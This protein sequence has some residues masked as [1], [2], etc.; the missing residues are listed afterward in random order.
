ML[1]SF[2]TILEPSD[3]VAYKQVLEIIETRYSAGLYRKIE[4]PGHG[5]VEVLL[6]APHVRPIEVSDAPGHLVLH[7]K[8]REAFSTTGVAH[9]M[10]QLDK[11]GGFVSEL[12]PMCPPYLRRHALSDLK[13]LLYRVDIDAQLHAFQSFIQEMPDFIRHLFPVAPPA[14]RFALELGSLNLA[15]PRSTAISTRW[16]IRC[17]LWL[18]DRS[19]GV[20]LDTGDFVLCG[21]S[22]CG[23]GGRVATR[24]QGNGRPFDEESFFFRRNTQR[25][26]REQVPETMRSIVNGRLTIRDLLQ[27]LP[28]SCPMCKKDVQR[29]K[30]AS[31]QIAYCTE[32]GHILWVDPALEPSDAYAQAS[33][34]YATQQMERGDLLRP[35]I[36]FAA[37]VK[38]FPDNVAY[39]QSLREVVRRKHPD[40]KQPSPLAGVLRAEIMRTVT[41]ARREGDWEAV[42]QALEDG[43]AKEPL[44]GFLQMELGDCCR[45]RGFRHAAIYAYQ[46]ALEVM[47]NR[48]DI[49]KL[50]QELTGES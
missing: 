11:A 23:P 18:I 50:V 45:L 14:S 22:G 33:F 30:L 19:T 9:G 17:Q 8:M 1:R 6:T 38:R 2:T 4:E 15:A 10:W 5:A 27:C 36:A 3:D 24:G 41:K 43:V 20:A 12:R 42:Q 21:F 49:R 25:W 44:D 32:C 39:R 28:G 47:P 13:R 40:R 35:R 26:L 29:D 7:Q 46:C 34:E 37:L 31:R 16:H 48:E